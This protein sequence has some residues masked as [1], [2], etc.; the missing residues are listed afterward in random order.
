M[1]YDFPAHESTRKRRRWG[2]T[3]GCVLI[4]IILIIGAAISF[5]L[6]LKQNREFPRYAMMD[7]N[8]D[9]FG[10]I[11]LNPEDTGVTDFTNFLFRRMEKAEK[12]GTDPNQ[13]KAMGVML[14][15][16]KSFLNQFLQPETMLYS[17]YNSETADESIVMTVPLKNRLAWLAMN[18]YIH[19]NIAETPV[20]TQGT[21]N[22]YELSAASPDSTGTLLSLD[23][24]NIVLSDSQPMLLRS[25]TYA[26]DSTHIG[27]PTT[28]LQRFI[29]ELSLDEPVAGEDLSVAMLN[30]P[31]RITNLIHV[32]EDFVGISGLSDQVSAAL[33]T[34]NL[35]L[36]D[37]TGI[38]LTADLVSADQI[39]GEFTLY[40]KTRDTSIRMAKVLQAALPKVNGNRAGSPFTFKGEAVGRDVTVVV[41][42]ELTGIKGWIEQ[43]VPVP[44]TAAADAAPETPADADPVAPLAQ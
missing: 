7:N 2:C 31:S 8:V 9:G 6:G 43:L 33:S 5:Y 34:Q 10:V 18:Q 40:C 11:R 42:L 12:A 13:A 38:K 28:E 39:K 1:S 15:V 17:S 16:S 24:D 21:A 29:D 35:T 23:P 3:C 30:E 32:F 36:D 37:I 4:L 44:E 20:T 19:K 27:T 41:S 26:A 14:K 22:I 25:L